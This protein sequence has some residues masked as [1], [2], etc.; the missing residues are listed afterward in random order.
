[1]NTFMGLGADVANQV[2]TT[3]PSFW[4]KANT[5]LTKVVQPA[6]N[7]YSQVVNKPT[8]T[9]GVIQQPTSTYFPTNDPTTN[10]TPGADL[11]PKNN[12]T[13]YLIIGGVVLAVGTGI[14]FATRK[15][16]K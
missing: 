14:Y 3:Q 6:A 15:S 13:K 12:T 7:I 5:I 4:D 1:M 11:R 8:S 16:K 2:A 10:D 9:P